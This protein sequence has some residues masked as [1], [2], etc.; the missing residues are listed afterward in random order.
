L[1]SAT[2]TKLQINYELNNIYVCQDNVYFH[3]PS[4][5]VKNMT[6]MVILGIPFIFMLYPFKAK[7]NEVSTV[8]MGVSVKFHFDSRFVI[9]ISQLS[10]SLVHAKTLYCLNIS[11]D[12][13]I[14]ETNTSEIGFRGILKQLASPRSSEQIVRFHY[15]S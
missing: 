4:V 6:D 2:G 9:N 5:L 8:K 12:Y 3:I 13:K 10:P 7:I 15:G 11:S 14:V 1:N